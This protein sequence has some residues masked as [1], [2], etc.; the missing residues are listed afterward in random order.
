MST[1]PVPKRGGARSKA[2]PPPPAPLNRR[3]SRLSKESLKKMATLAVNDKWAPPRKLT[4]AELQRARTLFFEIDSDSSGS[5]DADELGMAMRRLGQNPS[6]QELRELI[7]SVDEG[8][9]DGKLQFREFCKLF[10]LGMDSK[11]QARQS[12]VTDCF[13][14]MGGDPRDDESRI[15]AEDL[16]NSLLSDFDLTVDF[17]E[18]FGVQQQE[19]TRQDL[20]RIVMPTPRGVPS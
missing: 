1:K 17:G 6:Q 16:K 5:I 18:V 12:D 8:D 14:R 7:F 15:E 11:G 3:M 2:H 19:L 20:E 10:A 4:D 13:S 9:M